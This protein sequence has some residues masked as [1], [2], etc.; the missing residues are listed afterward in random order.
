MVE[1]RIAV[2]DNRYSRQ[3]G[4]NHVAYVINV[5]CLDQASAK[6]FAAPTVLEVQ[7]RFREFHSLHS[8]LTT[9]NSLISSLPFPSRVTLTSTSVRTKRQ[10]KLD[11]WLKL[12]YKMCLGNDECLS[13]LYGFLSVST[14]GITCTVLGFKE[15]PVSTVAVNSDS[16]SVDKGG[17]N[18]AKTK[19][20]YTVQVTDMD[21]N[22][23]TIVHRFSEFYEL[24][25][26]T[27]KFNNRRLTEGCEFPSRVLGTG[28]WPLLGLEGSR[29][30]AIQVDDEPAEGLNGA[31]FLDE[32]LQDHH[33]EHERMGLSKKKL[34]KKKGKG[35]EKTTTATPTDNGQ[36]QTIHDHLEKLEREQEW[37]G[38][39]EL[40]LEFDEMCICS[41]TSGETA[42]VM[43]AIILQHSASTRFH[44]LLLHGME[45][46]YKHTRQ[47]GNIDLKEFSSLGGVAVLCYS[48]KKNIGQV[49]HVKNV[50]N[51][52]H[53]VSIADS[54]FKGSL[55]PY[56]NQTFRDCSLLLGSGGGQWDVHL[57]ALKQI[58]EE[59]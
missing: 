22:E 28:G 14:S 58:A 54:E 1:L 5:I 35:G 4:F 23:F 44:E 55:P 29:A 56:A 15:L 33:E 7:R 24:F 2:L 9:A 46:L 17:N 10:E 42:R 20:F 57:G 3:G 13:I 38:A 36:P 12:A 41:G 49:N 30:S 59:I 52:L 43:L 50:L 16:D 21:K 45:F 26:K 32:I 47:E 40:I 48:L 8:R 51:L 25:R 37:L 11:S 31:D 27:K 39:K 6:R 53:D 19:V 18:N 34:F